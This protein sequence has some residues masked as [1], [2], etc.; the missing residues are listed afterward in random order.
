MMAKIQTE[1]P[2]SAAKVWQALLK[3]DTFLY[4]TRG[5]LGF[6]QTDQWPRTFRKEVQIETRLFFF[7]LIPGWKHRLRIVKVDEEQ[8]ELVSEEQ[9]FIIRQWNHRISLQKE[10][11]QR[12]RYTDEI[13]IKAGL[14]TPLIWAYAHL[15]Y[16]YRQRRWRRLAKRL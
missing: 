5:M 16:R 7:H 1:L 12:C 14:L 15:F 11:A 3:R 10:S 8:R 2:S 6:R 4:I 13:E 9:G